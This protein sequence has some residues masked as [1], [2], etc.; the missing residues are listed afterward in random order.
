[1]HRP[2]QRGL[3]TFNS[4][5]EGHIIEK[6][7]N[8]GGAGA[9]RGAYFRRRVGF[10]HLTGTDLRPGWPRSRRTGCLEFRPPVS[11]CRARASNCALWQM[12]RTTSWHTC[13]PPWRSMCGGDWARRHPPRPTPSYDG[14]A[15]IVCDAVNVWMCVC[16][17]VQNSIAS[18]RL[19]STRSELNFWMLVNNE[20]KLI[21]KE[22]SYW[23]LQCNL[24]FQKWQ[25]LKE[26]TPA[27]RTNLPEF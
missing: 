11:R 9:A 17:F 25:Q 4:S 2:L 22:Y 23:Y 26:L 16:H 27:N 21:Q 8:C 13:I 15:F 19:Q 6:R 7:D 12:R 1:M 3:Q 18:T 24:K 14:F 10:E 5:P 20:N